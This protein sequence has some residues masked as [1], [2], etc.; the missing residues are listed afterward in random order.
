METERDP[1][2]FVLIAPVFPPGNE[3]GAAD[4]QRWFLQCRNQKQRLT[5]CLKVL[6]SIG[7]CGDPS[8]EF[9]EKRKEY[10]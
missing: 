8:P 9:W 2:D 6:S 5:L 7:Y 3:I 10:L 4:F 1:D